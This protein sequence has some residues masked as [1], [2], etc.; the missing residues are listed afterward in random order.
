MS[1][2]SKSVEARRKLLKGAF[3]I[4]LTRAA[5]I[6][7][8]EIGA[9]QYF[10]LLQRAGEDAYPQSIK[11]AE[12]KR[13]QEK[14]F[15]QAVLDKAPR[16]DGELVLV[17]DED[18]ERT[19]CFGTQIKEEVRVWGNGIAYLPSDWFAGIQMADLVAYTLNR[20]WILKHR[21]RELEEG[22]MEE[23]AVLRQFDDIFLD[24]LVSLKPLLHNLLDPGSLQIEVP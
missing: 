22:R 23:E 12:P 16:F 13:G 18:N 21:V 3:E 14:V 11:W 8:V 24:F 7:Y 1:L 17:Q 9:K 5:S 19:T 2:G 15:Y 20:R 10:E 4:L 6:V